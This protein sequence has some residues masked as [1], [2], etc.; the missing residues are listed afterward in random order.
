MNLS[1]MQQDIRL[2][3]QDVLDQ[4]H[5][6]RPIIVERISTGHAG[7]PPV[8]IDEQFLRWAYAH[9]SVAGI[10][11]FLH[12]D[13]RT[14]RRSLLAYGIAEPQENPFTDQELY[15]TDEQPVHL[16]NAAPSDDLLEPEMPIPDQLPSEFHSDNLAAPR[17][18]LSTPHTTSYTGPLSTI[19]DD[20]LDSLVMRLRGH[21]RRAGI[22][23]MDGMLRRLGHHVPRERIRASLMRIDPIRRVFERIRIRRRVYS[24]P[25][26]NSLWHHDGQHGMLYQPLYYYILTSYIR[27]YQMGHCYSWFH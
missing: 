15:D 25:G 3:Y 21:F 14:V 6:G 20:D 11:R 19:T 9:R 5:F 12:V 8:Y 13:R 22:T 4:S 1:L 2:Q 7:R 27:S 23:M 10:A 16:E 17:V 18:S 24:V 26:P